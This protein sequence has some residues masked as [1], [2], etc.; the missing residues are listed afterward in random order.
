M[1]QPSVY[2]RG[3]RVLLSNYST[4]VALQLS[5]PGGKD[6]TGLSPSPPG[7]GWDTCQ[8]PVSSRAYRASGLPF[9][10]DIAEALLRGAGPGAR[11]GTSTQMEGRWVALRRPSRQKSI[12]LRHL[13]P[14]KEGP[15]LKPQG[16]QS[17]SV[18]D[19]TTHRRQGHRSHR[20]LGGWG[21]ASSPALALLYPPLF[22][23]LRTARAAGQPQQTLR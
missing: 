18:P 19:R 15:S 12:L 8:T 16:S 6:L 5:S 20:A 10:S 14:W 11:Q 7:S 2:H 13:D 21:E 23:V 17:R 22:S 4:A 3:A 9:R 1:F